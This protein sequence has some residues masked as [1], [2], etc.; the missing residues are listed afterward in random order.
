VFLFP[1]LKGV[2]IKKELEALKMCVFKIQRE[3]K[4]VASLKTI[5]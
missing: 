5:D 4:N 2:K 1:G 3:G